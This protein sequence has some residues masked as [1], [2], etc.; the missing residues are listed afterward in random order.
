[1]VVPLTADGFR[2][3]VSALP[4]LAEKEGVRF[5]TFTLPKDGCVRL[6][7]KDLGRGMHESVV[8]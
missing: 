8:Q 2:A 6:L 1:M 5:H 3:T 4:S 7:L